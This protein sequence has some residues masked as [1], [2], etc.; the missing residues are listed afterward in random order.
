M[1]RSGIAYAALLDWYL[2]AHWWG[3]KPEEWD[4]LPQEAQELNL[5]V[6]RSSLQIE[7]LLADPRYAPKEPGKRGR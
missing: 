6:Y 4:A 7:A 2:C 5:A 1:R 3:Y